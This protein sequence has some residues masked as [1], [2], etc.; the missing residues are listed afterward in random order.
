MRHHNELRTLRVFL[1]IIR[2]IPDIRIIQRSFNLVQNAERRGLQFQHREQNRNGG[3]RAFAAGEQRQELQFLSRRLGVDLDA[4]VQRVV[5]I[6]QL[7]FRM[8]AAEQ[9]RERLGEVPLHLREVLDECRTHLNQQPL[10]EFAQVHFR[11]LQVLLLG[12]QVV[13]ARLGFGVFLHRPNV[14][15]SQCANL[16]LQLGGAA[17]AFLLVEGRAAELLCP[18]VGQLVGVPDAVLQIL[19][20]ALDARLRQLGLV[21][22]LAVAVVGFVQ[23]LHVAEDVAQVTL[24]L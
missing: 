4:A 24:R 7:Q 2:V 12:G 11:A 13:H 16:P 21:Q 17:V 20:V 8:A 18:G 14:D 9:P 10:D 19:L 23:V 6:H 3:Q 15:R 1:Q 5:R 22:L